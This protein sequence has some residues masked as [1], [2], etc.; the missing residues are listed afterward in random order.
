VPRCVLCA[1][2]TPRECLNASTT[3]IESLLLAAFLVVFSRLAA[4]YW[5][6]KC[7]L[8]SDAN[9]TAIRPI[10]TRGMLHKRANK[11][12]RQDKACHGLMEKR[13]SSACSFFVCLGERTIASNHR[14]LWPTAVTI[15]SR[16][17]ST[18]L[19]RP[20]G[21]CDLLSIVWLPLEVAFPTNKKNTTFHEDG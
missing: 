6:G 5:L 13:L 4:V 8:S 18:L 10:R 12:P 15:L 20:N 7:S 14:P 2:R 9:H 16:S 1:E 11:T 3:N 19:F 21:K 17:K